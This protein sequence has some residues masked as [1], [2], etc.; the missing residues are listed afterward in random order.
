MGF[1]IVHGDIT[2]LGVEA[3]VNAANNRCLGGGGVDGAIHAAAGRKLYEECLS[4]HGCETGDAK[5]T[6][7]Y[8][9]SK[10]VI[11]TVGPVWVGGQNNEEKLL[12]SCYKKSLQIAK[13]LK[14]KTL[15]FPLIS[16]GAYLYPREQAIKVATSEIENF[17][18]DNDMEI[19]L[20][21]YNK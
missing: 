21:L 5:Y 10:Y 11:H 14:V 7:G 9:L 15:A 20:C 3:V 2:K 17:L 18:K 4:L 13:E 8:N 6:K 12:R 19:I 16:A 1:Q